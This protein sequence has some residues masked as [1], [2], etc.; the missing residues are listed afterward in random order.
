MLTAAGARALVAGRA[1]RQ[2]T[3]SINERVDI[4]DPKVPE[5]VRVKALK[6]FRAKVKGVY[7]IVNPGDVVMVEGPV[8]VDLRVA[9]KA[10]MTDEPEKTQVNYLPERKRPKAAKE[11]KAA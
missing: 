2:T 10:V 6:G 11:A 9:N 4:M 8:A 7:S 5:F 1:A 3:R